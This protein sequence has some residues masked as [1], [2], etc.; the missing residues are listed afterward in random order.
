MICLLS[1]ILDLQA[2]AEKNWNHVIGAI[3]DLKNG[4][5]ITNETFATF[6][7]SAIATGV[8]DPSL[9]E[10]ANE[11]LKESQLLLEET[12][13]QR[14]NLSD[15]KYEAVNSIASSNKLPYH[16]EERNKESKKVMTY[17][18]YFIF[19]LYFFHLE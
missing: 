5:S 3:D 14:L 16:F 6:L 12:S 4:L 15:V 17:L 18:V 13:Q 8:T 1:Y 7:D 11:L 2:T 10:Q 9:I 19:G